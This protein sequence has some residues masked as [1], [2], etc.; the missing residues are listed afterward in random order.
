MEMPKLKYGIY[1]M[2]QR[3]DR[4]R[5]TYRQS[6]DTVS[7]NRGSCLIDNNTTSNNMF[8]DRVRRISQKVDTMKLNDDSLENKNN[9]LQ[10][11]TNFRDKSSNL[12]HLEMIRNELHN[13]STDYCD[14]AMTA[15]V[16]S[17]T[18]PTTTTATTTITTTTIK[19]IALQT[20]YNSQ[21]YEDIDGNQTQGDKLNQMKALRRRHS[22]SVNVFA[23]L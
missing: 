22:R 5:S 7:S 3:V 8:K 21:H 13:T 4:E 17:T 15:T 20:S 19:P 6:S 11:Y 16:T 1:S 18:K 9:E 2:K 10:R 23:A 14:T 12:Q